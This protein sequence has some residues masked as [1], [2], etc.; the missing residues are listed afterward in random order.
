[1]LIKILLNKFKNILTF[2][3]FME[4]NSLK[5]QLVKDSF[6]NFTST[7]LSRLGGLIFTIILARY[8]LPEK[9]GIY[10]L[11]ISVMLIFLTFADLGLNTALI[12]FFSREY[13]GGD[14]KRARKYFQYLFSV[15]LLLTIIVGLILFVLAYPIS[16]FI[17]KKPTLFIPIIISSFYLFI[18]SLEGFFQ[19]MFYI[20]KKVNFIFIKEILLQTL[21]IS[22]VL[23]SFYIIPLAYYVS[24]SIFVLI[25]TSMVV[26]GF[27]LLLLRKLVPDL[28]IKSDS[29]INKKKLINFTFWVS[30]A[31]ISTVFF[32][33]IDIMMIGIFI[34]E[35]SFTA[36][37]RVAFS[38]VS[39][40]SGLFVFGSVLL[41]VF[42]QISKDRLDY[43]VNQVIK[44]LL[45]FSVP[46]AAGLALLSK[47]IIVMIYGYEYLPASLPLFFLAFLIIELVLEGLLLS[48][49]SSQDKPKY[50]AR[51]VIV[52]TILNV[53]LN[54]ALIF[55][56]LQFSKIW[57]ITGAAIATL[58]SRYFHLGYLFYLMKKDLKIKIKIKNIIRPIISAAIMYFILQ[59][60]LVAKIADINLL[61]GIGI[62]LLGAIIYFI[63][64]TLIKGISKI[65][66]EL[67]G[68][69]F[70]ATI[71]KR[72]QNIL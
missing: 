47:Y 60:F 16:V 71:L 5:K 38:L 39:G 40:I 17:F 53:I 2:K 54:I 26:T 65:E 50:Y 8:L 1:L 9:F 18:F 58:V 61:N 37:Y 19:S 27:Y 59:T 56:L 63:V 44:F 4:K 7:F 72:D 29:K 20:I 68:T 24:S 21:R 33:Y 43:A 36:F 52:S 45:I 41:S 42:S 10:N 31:S 66:I 23:I 48:L 14:K 46:T 12:R 67:I 30:I 62:I 15:K 11:A 34:S 69:I 28:F 25:L 64:L 32:S 70:R 22:L 57:A 3:Y 6:W 51:G 55:Y 13:Y 35:A 49:F